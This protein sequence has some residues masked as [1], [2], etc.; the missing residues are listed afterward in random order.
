MWGASRSPKSGKTIRTF[1]GDRL[2]KDHTLPSDYSAYKDKLINMVCQFESLWDRNFGWISTVQHRIDLKKTDSLP[3][4]S[5]PYGAGPSTK[6]FEIQEINWMFA[7]PGIEPV[8]TEWASP[9][10]FVPRKVWTLSFCIN[11]RKLIAMKIWDLYSVVQMDEGVD[12]LCDVT[13]FLTLGTNSRHWQ[14]EIMEEDRAKTNFMSYHGLLCF[15]CM[16]IRLERL[17]KQWTSYSRKWKS[18]RNSPFSI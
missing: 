11:Y 17:N 3:I 7:I 1:F 16:R 12:S 15:T 6:E 13:I 4:Y 2:G 10:V 8:Q 5:V 18:S 9:I 14:G